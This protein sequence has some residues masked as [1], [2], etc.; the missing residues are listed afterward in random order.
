MPDQKTAVW[1]FLKILPEFEFDKSVQYM[2]LTI[3]A[4]D[5]SLKRVGGC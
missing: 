2:L 5:G 3:V 1:E 4:S